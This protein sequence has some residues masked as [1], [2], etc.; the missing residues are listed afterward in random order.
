MSRLPGLTAAERDPV[1]Q[2]LFESITGGARAQSD[3]KGRIESRM[4]GPLLHSFCCIV[5]S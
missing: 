3:R 2:A 5:P 1:Q 4:P